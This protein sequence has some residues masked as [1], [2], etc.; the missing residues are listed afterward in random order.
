MRLPVLET[1]R[2]TIRPFLPEDFEA[3]D[4]VNQGAWG[5][6]GRREYLEWS[7]RNTEELA[8]L[9][10][11]PYGDR[12]VIRR[13]TG[14]LIGVVGLVPAF[15][16]F[17]VLP[18]FDVAPDSPAGR[19]NTPEFG[20]YWA[21]HPDHQRRGYA[22][23]AARALTDFAFTVMNLRRIVATTEYENHASQAVM[24][25]LGMRIERNP[26]PEPP[27]FQIVGVLENT[28]SDGA[29]DGPRRA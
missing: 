10:Q 8:Q 18:G 19:R 14:E 28:V 29:T 5:E 26:R 21:V 7:V 3:F 9:Y 4:R 24:R 23:E 12:P 6:P 25:H 15:G 27:W 22:T 1:E 13:E 2:L 20:L 11:P 16:P 17:G